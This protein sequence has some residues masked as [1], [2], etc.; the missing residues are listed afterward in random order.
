MSDIDPEWQAY[1]R[2]V[3]AAATFSPTEPAQALNKFIAF[4]REFFSVAPATES[5]VMEW[6]S[7]ANRHAD[8][9]PLAILVK[10]WI[11]YVYHARTGEV[12][13]CL[14]LGRAAQPFYDEYISHCR[15]QIVN[16]LVAPRSSVKN[17]LHYAD[18]CQELPDPSGFIFH[19]SRCGSTLVSGCLAQLEYCSVLSESPLLTEVLLARNIGLAEKKSLL[20]LCL[21][22]QGRP[23]PEQPHVIVKWN[24]WDIFYWELIREVWPQVPVLFLTRDP[25]E[26]LASHARSAGRHMSGDP[27][28]A[29]VQD[30]FGHSRDFQSLLDYRIAVLQGLMTKMLQ[31]HKASEV[32]LL[33]Y[34]ALDEAIIMGIGAHFGIEVSQSQRITLRQKLAYH[35][36]SPGVQFQ[37]NAEEKRQHLSEPE[38]TGINCALSGLYNQLISKSNK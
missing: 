19:L 11:P 7:A 23:S 30:F 17:L 29:H 25:V 36:K 22:L 28:L 14:P 16:A 38:I 34:T 31:V 24:A 18:Q 15:Q 32:S 10:D 2:L 20:R 27:V 33:D 21:H 4:A 8:W 9:V 37:P 3:Q 35:S 1:H 26:I 13:W 6:L 12:S 5:G